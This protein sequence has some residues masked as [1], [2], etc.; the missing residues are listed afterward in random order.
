VV[1]SQ[2]FVATQ[3]CIEERFVTG[4]DMPALL[5]VGCEGLWGLFGLFV[6]LAVL[7]HTPGAHG[8]PVEDTI[9]AL[10][11]IHNSPRVLAFLV[12]NACSIAVFNAIGVT[13]T[14]TASAAY[15]MVLDSMRTI[16]VWAFGL[17]FAG[18]SFHPLQLVGFAFLALGAML[19]NE[20]VALPCSAAYP[21]ERQREEDKARLAERRLVSASRS[22]GRLSSAEKCHASADYRLY[23]LS[24][25]EAGGERLFD[26]FFTPHLSRWTA[27]FNR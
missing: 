1:V 5:T 12:A 23:E 13:I 24:D 7:Q 8:H 10:A 27:H 11:Q 21:S 16:G 25:A 15:R 9:D 4:H 20:A 22:S 17:A 14:K 18:E 3:M 26:D 6:L 2:L 19:Y